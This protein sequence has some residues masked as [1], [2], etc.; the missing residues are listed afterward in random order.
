MR[1]S[2]W[3]PADNCTELSP[4]TSGGVPVTVGCAIAIE[5]EDEDGSSRNVSLGLREFCEIRCADT[6][7]ARASARGS[8]LTGTVA[9][10]NEMGM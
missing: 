10:P 7:P 1:N 4:Y 2:N 8:F 9:D 5:A 3:P 6:R